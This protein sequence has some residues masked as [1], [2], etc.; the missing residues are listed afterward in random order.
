MSQQTGAK[1][2]KKLSLEHAGR[3]VWATLHAIM[4]FW[5]LAVI[6]LFTPW[7]P[8]PALF[9]QPSIVRALLGLPLF[10]FC[11][12]VLGRHQNFWIGLIYP[13]AILL[14]ERIA[15]AISLSSQFGWQYF[16]RFL[17]RAFGFGACSLVYCYAQLGGYGLSFM[18]GRQKRKAAA[19]GKEP[20][21]PHSAAER[22]WDASGTLPRKQWLPVAVFV[23]V[24]LVLLIAAVGALPWFSRNGVTTR[25][26]PRIIALYHGQLAQLE[27]ACRNPSARQRIFEDLCSDP[28][29]EEAGISGDDIKHTYKTPRHLLISDT[30]PL[31]WWL[32][33]DHRYDISVGEATTETLQQVDVIRITGRLR[34]DG[35]AETGYYYYLVAN[36]PETL[37]RLAQE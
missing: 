17:S 7:G 19:L 20:S 31:L 9:P 2:V 33:G 26:A 36:L 25:D 8:V 37:D 6:W 12:W 23:V 16:W 32:F 34:D 11:G 14:G 4:L 1:K 3:R 21:A 28:A 30:W 5:L 13:A 29:I 10:W 15:P 24:G 35:G 27:Q 18:M 22:S